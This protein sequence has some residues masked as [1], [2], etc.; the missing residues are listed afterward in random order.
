MPFKHTYE[1]LSIKFEANQLNSFGDMDVSILLLKGLSNA[2]KEIWY[3]W[4]PQSGFYN[5]D[6]IDSGIFHHTIIGFT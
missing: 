4:L 1:Y 6:C 2:V 5:I 3:I